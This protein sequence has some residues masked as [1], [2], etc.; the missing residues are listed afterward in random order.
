MN[1]LFAVIKSR[2]PAWNDDLIMDDQADWPA[3]AALMDALVDEGFIVLGGPLEGSADV[4]LIIRAA[5]VE[6]IV[7]RF[8]ADPWVE[9]GLLVDK[10]ILPWR[11]RLGSLGQR[12]KLADMEI[13]PTTAQA[14]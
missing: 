6:E 11:I 3:H 13:R 7:N 2:G 8:A 12:Q 10:Q 14:E 9:N 1:Q 4:L 5:T